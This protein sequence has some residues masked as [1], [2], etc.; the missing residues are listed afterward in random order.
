VIQAFSKAF[1]GFSFNFA[2]LDEDVL[3]LRMTLCGWTYLEIYAD[4]VPF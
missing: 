1:T 2:G 4:I 3:Q